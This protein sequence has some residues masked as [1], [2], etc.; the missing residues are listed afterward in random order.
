M[1]FK[2]EED[3]REFSIEKL[4]NSVKTLIKTLKELMRKTD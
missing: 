2:F 4:E 3:F 1:Y